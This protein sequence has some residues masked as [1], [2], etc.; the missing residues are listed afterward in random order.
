MRVLIEEALAA[1]REAERQLQRAV[2]GDREAL[3]FEVAFHRKAFQRLSSEHMMER[4]DALK[5]AES[6]RHAEQPSTER[7]HR[8]AREEKA[9]A[10]EIWDNAR[11]NDED[12]P[13]TH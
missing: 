13:G 11:S 2:D 7:Y 3:E 8:V 1:W 12:T 9:I 4:I 5:D 10:A 6:R